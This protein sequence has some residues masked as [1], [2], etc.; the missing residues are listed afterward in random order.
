M[1]LEV[2]PTALDAAATVAT[3][4]GLV[5]PA[6]AASNG[7]SIIEE[8]DDETEDI[9]KVNPFRAVLSLYSRRI[10]VVSAPGRRCLGEVQR[11]SYNFRGLANDTEGHTRLRCS[12]ELGSFS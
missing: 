4:V 2:L 5:L 9:G 10:K 8:D 6:E 7:F 3:V 12:R 1:L 11:L